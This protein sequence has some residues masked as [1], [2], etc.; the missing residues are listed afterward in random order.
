MSI[1]TSFVR[2]GSEEDGGYIVPNIFDEVKVSNCFSPGVG[3]YSDFEICSCNMIQNSSLCL[4]SK[5]HIF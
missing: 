5:S 3:E 4:K 1:Q 2:I